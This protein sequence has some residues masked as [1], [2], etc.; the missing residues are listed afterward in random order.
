MRQG[1]VTLG[2]D[3]EQVF[4]VLGAPVRRVRYDRAGTPQVWIYRGHKLHQGYA[5][6]ASLYRLVF[7]DGRLRVLEPIESVSGPQRSG[8]GSVQMKKPAGL[9]VLVLAVATVATGQTP[10]DPEVEPRS[11]ARSPRGPSAGAHVRDRR[12]ESGEGR[13]ASSR[14][15]SVPGPAT[16][17]LLRPRHG[18]HGRGRTPRR[19]PAH[20]R[21][22]QLEGAEPGHRHDR[23]LP[24]RR[25]LQP[26]RQR[27]RR[28]V[29]GPDA[30]GERGELPGHRRPVRARRLLPG[31]R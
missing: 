31:H 19:T 20:L 25:R 21:R 16:R 6:G 28:S 9:A 7:L 15:D 22:D 30:P 12:A 3:E 10:A 1:H 8:P 11:T 2:M 29:P 24:R 4:A 17:G 14:A 27:L 23:Q 13:R 26:R 18:A 5:H